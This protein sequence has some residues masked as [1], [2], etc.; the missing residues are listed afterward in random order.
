[1]CPHKAAQTITD[2]VYLC[3]RRHLLADSKACIQEKEI[4]LSCRVYFEI[5]CP[6]NAHDIPAIYIRLVIVRFSLSEVV[7][8]KAQKKVLILP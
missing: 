8:K 3:F 1:M 6:V 2:V 4:L 5:L 7:N